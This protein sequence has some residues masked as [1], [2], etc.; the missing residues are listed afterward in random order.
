MPRVHTELGEDSHLALTRALLIY[1]N[2][3]DA[4]ISE[5]KVVK[6]EIRAGK[7]LSEP[8]LKKLLAKLSPGLTYLDER[9]LYHSGTEMAWFEPAQ[10][11]VMFF[12]THDPFL[13][14]L[15]GG[16][17]PQP[18]LVFIAVRRG[19]YVHACLA[20]DRPRPE[21][22]LAVAP[23]YNVSRGSVCLGSG[24]LK[25]RDLQGYSDAFWN[26]AFTHGTNS[27][28]AQNWPGS[29]GELWA[30]VR[31]QGAFPLHTLRPSLT[32]KGAAACMQ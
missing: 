29:Y 7:V 30:H 31:D 24:N 9:T 11:R 32:L 20:P 17:F 3:S 8:V 12:D 26:T 14:S 15:S 2:A 27:L 23:Y 10:S 25:S 16:T 6:G 1:E 28:L 22:T 5:H 13:N 18:P 19:L 4:Y 21:T